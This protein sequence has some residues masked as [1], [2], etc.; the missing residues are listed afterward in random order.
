MAQ[1]SGRLDGVPELSVID[2]KNV[3]DTFKQTNASHV[4]SNLPVLDTGGRLFEHGHL[5]RL[6]ERR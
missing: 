5:A 2:R 6:P 1:T 4:E 3:L